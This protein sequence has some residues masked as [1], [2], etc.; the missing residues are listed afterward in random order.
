MKRKKTAFEIE[1]KTISLSPA[2]LKLAQEA[3][4]EYFSGNLS[5]YL[6]SLISQANQCT[7][8]RFS[9]YKNGKP[10]L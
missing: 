2:T 8:C 1:R 3:A 5:A 9:I 6:A 4:N 10:A 7:H